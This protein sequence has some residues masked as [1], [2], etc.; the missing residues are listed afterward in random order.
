MKTFFSKSPEDTVKLGGKIGKRLKPGSIVALKGELASGKTVLTK[1]IAAGLGVSRAG[2]VNSPT[3]LILKEYKGKM[4]LY[5]FD[6]YRLDGLKDLATVGYEEYLFG[7]GVCVI[8]WADKI[9]GLL[10]KGCFWI[11]L[12]V[13]GEF[14]RKIKVSDALADRM[15]RR[16]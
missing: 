2:Y 14:E 9:K 7:N 3:F 16:S 12:A 1:G 8:E 5:H 15:K 13:T 6:L 11:Q 4:P 10:P